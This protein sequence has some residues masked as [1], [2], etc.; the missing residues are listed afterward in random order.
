MGS[1]V[2]LAYDFEDLTFPN[3]WDNFGTKADPPVRVGCISP[4]SLAA[5]QLKLRSGNRHRPYE[6]YNTN[7]EL[8][9]DCFAKLGAYVEE[10]AAPL[11]KK[12]VHKG[13]ACKYNVIM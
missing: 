3:I 1:R 7:D 5:T 9:Y 10:K 8:P 13:D 11:R 2:K 6:M 4:P 12:F